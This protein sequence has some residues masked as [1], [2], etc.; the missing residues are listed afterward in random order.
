MV[1]FVQPLWGKTIAVQKGATADQINALIARA[2]PYSVLEFSEGEFRLAK[3]LL[4]ERDHITLKG[5]ASGKTVLRF[6]F[7]AGKGGDFIRIAGSGK[8]IANRFGKD[9]RRGEKHFIS[10]FDT[11]LKA[12]DHLYLE[13]P[14]TLS[15]FEENNWQNLDLRTAIS[16]SFREMITRVTRVEGKRVEIE[17]EM[18]F[19]F[20]ADRSTFQVINMREGVRLENLTFAS[21]LGKSDPLAFKNTYLEYHSTAAIRAFQTSGLVLE[22]LTFIDVPS[23]AIALDRALAAK[24][25]Q[26]VIR[27]SHNKG[28]AGNG[29][30]IELREVFNSDL[31][32]LHITD[33]RHAVLFSSWHAEVG[34]L[35]HIEY[36]NRDINFHGSPDHSNTV[37]IDEMMLQ[38]DEDVRGGKP[39]HAWRALSFGGK[40]HARTNFVGDNEISFKKA[41]GGWRMDILPASK[42]GS[43]LDGRTGG[44]FLVGQ[45]G[46]DR[47]TGGAGWDKFYS[48]GGKDIIT[49]FSAGRYGDLLFVDER[50]KLSKTKE[51]VLVLYENTEVLLPGL[52]DPRELKDN[53]VICNRACVDEKLAKFER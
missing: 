15:Y 40:N 42:S 31:T 44:D 43:I 50:P 48:G 34:N 18:A 17:S 19:G 32:R 49:D 23:K 20:T 6:A 28:I 7:E 12:G 14:N 30:G 51:G 46:N 35:V 38:Y 13:R 2:A 24:V 1:F 29:Y 53:I 36:T 16:R 47:M 52:S 33:V 25:D 39:R 22:N 10:R 26:I 5:H 45:E 8:L 21:A 4:I 3:P 11:S 9:A 27:G 37:L 41:M